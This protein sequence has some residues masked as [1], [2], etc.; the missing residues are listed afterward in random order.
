MLNYAVFTVRAICNSMDAI[1]KY[2]VKEQVHIIKTLVK[3]N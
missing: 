3:R 2:F 1:F